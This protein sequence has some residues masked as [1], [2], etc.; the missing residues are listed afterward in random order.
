M[1]SEYKTKICLPTFI[2]NS[3]LCSQIIIITEKCEINNYNYP[4]ANFF[5]HC[6]NDYL[7][8]Y[9]SGMFELAKTIKMLRK[10]IT[11]FFI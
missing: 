4:R 10:N 2:H 11:R 7:F 6:L 1:H 9:D 5:T 8:A 3:L